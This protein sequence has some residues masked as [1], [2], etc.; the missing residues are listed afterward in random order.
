[1][2]WSQNSSRCV[3]WHYV[4]GTY[5]NH[6][7]LW[8]RRLII[9]LNLRWIRTLPCNLLL[10]VHLIVVI[11]FFMDCIIKMNHILLRSLIPCLFFSRLNL[12][13]LLIQLIH[14]LLSEIISSPISQRFLANFFECSLFCGYFLPA[15]QLKH[16]LFSVNLALTSHIYF[17][18][19]GYWCPLLLWGS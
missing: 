5:T 6:L 12:F 15:L 16:I 14:L 4:G 2:I 19:W 3:N 13:H 9:I 7:I 11:C 17:L 10:M 1:M 18:V 8:F